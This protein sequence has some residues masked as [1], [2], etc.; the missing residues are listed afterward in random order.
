MQTQIQ[1]HHD[2]DAAL[3]QARTQR[4]HV[5]LDFSAAPA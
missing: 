4:Q 1:W 5:L 3:E 2:F